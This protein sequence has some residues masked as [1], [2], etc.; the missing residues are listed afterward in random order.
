MSPAALIA[1]P[2]SVLVADLCPSPNIEPRFRGLEPTILVLHYTGLESVR[3]SLEVLSRPDC[4]VSC[5][6]VIDVDGRIVQM[7]AEEM[8][9]WHAGLSSWHGE[10]D[11]NSA[12]IGIEI[13]NPGHALGYPD[14]PAAQMK[15]VTAL[16]RDIAGRHGIAPERVLA[17]SDVAPA[18]KIDPGEKFDWP[19]LAREGV[20][21]WVPPLP[22]DPDDQ[23]PEPG[24][25]GEDIREARALLA[26]YGYGVA[27]SGPLDPELGFVLRAFQLHFRPARVDS[28]LDAST[29]A[30]L[31]R[32]VAAL[33]DAP[34]A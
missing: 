5:H 13:Q 6:Y 21:M 8:R 34:V 15:A 17:H 28:R 23:G 18:R 27:P 25:D 2:D 3:R 33:P 11:I 20:G 10:T 22:L 9:A 14:F 31:R 26:R 24:A 12:S 1:A 29:L 30:T 16:C 4:R 19:G 32:L 7:V